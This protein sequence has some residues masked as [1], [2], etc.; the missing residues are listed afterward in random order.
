MLLRLT[1]VADAGYASRSIFHCRQSGTILANISEKLLAGGYPPLSPSGMAACYFAHEWGAAAGP[2]VAVGCASGN[3]GIHQRQADHPTRGQYVDALNEFKLFYLFHYG[4][5]PDK[6]A[7]VTESDIQRETYIR[8]FLIRKAADL[9]IHASLDAAAMAANQMLSS[10]GRKGQT[11]TMNEFV[12]QVLR[13]EGLTATD[14]ENF[15]RHD[16]VIQQLV[17][18]IGLSGAL[19]TP[20]EVSSIYERE[21]QELSSQ[22]VFFPA[23][24]YFSSVKVTPDALGKF[25]TNYMAEYRLPDR[26]QI[27]YVAFNITNYLAPT[28]E[29]VGRAR[30]SKAQADSRCGLQYGAC[31]TFP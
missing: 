3:F 10:L 25:Y 2:N 7:N 28:K 26:V 18:T 19:I 9:G 15:A 6:K 14:F 27:N 11:V 22:I 17:Q 24:N 29:Y 4:T 16:V 13:P 5:W 8:L 21:H 12:T 20:E 31:W 30:I 23:R 1:T